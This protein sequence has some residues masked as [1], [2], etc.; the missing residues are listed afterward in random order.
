MVVIVPC[1]WRY[2][3]SG[4]WPCPVGHARAKRAR[5]LV[6]E[7]R[8]DPQV[9]VVKLAL[10][11]GREASRTSGPTLAECAERYLCT[12]RPKC[13]ILVNHSDYQAVT[14]LSELRWVVNR[15]QSLYPEH[16]VEY[17]FVTSPR[18]HWRIRFICRQFFP[19]IRARVFLSH[20]CPM[21]WAVEGLGY[22]K[23]GAI[24]L[25]GEARVERWRSR[26]VCPK[27]RK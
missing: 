1:S 23:L 22:A 2:D 18:H 5:Q 27:Y 26:I 7:A 20:D 21:S 19:G 16:T 17:W 6:E 3:E 12:T 14:T 24:L 4:Q 15:V 9:E 25:L 13:E 8:A 10:G 11:A